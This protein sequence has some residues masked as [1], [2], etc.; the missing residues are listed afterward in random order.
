MQEYVNFE[1]EKYGNCM[2]LDFENERIIFSGI[3]ITDNIPKWKCRYWSTLFDHYWK[4]YGKYEKI[5]F[6]AGYALLKGGKIVY[7]KIP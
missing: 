5:N 1:D 7:V 6:E 4:R 2:F 3:D